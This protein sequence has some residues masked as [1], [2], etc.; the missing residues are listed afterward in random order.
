M[1]LSDIFSLRSK[2]S[3]LRRLIPESPTYIGF[4]GSA[5][6]AI[7]IRLVKNKNNLNI[8]WIFQ[9]FLAEIFF[10]RFIKHGSVKGRILPT[11]SCLLL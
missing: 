4:G 11:I 3:K 7:F 8:E 2:K 6:S 1:I 10:E 5:I 9:K